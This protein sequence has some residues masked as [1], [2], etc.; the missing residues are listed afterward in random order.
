[1]I[2]VAPA[3]EQVEAQQSQSSPR[4]QIHGVA[5]VAL[6]GVLAFSIVVGFFGA[7]AF[8]LSSLQ[9]QRSQAQ[10]YASFR[11]LLDPSSPIAPSIGGV[12]PP[13]SPIALLNAP[14]ADMRNVVVVEGTSSGDT[15]AGPG[16]LRDSPLPGQV[17]ES[18]LMGRSSTAGSPFSGITGLR[19]GAV[20][21]VTTGQGT[22]RFIVEGDRVAGDELP[23]IPPSGA[24]LTLV[25]SAGSGWLGS[26]APSHL[27]YVD[28]YLKGK[29]VTAPSGRP[30]AVPSAEI[31]GHGDPSAWPFVLF[32]LE[33]LL[34]VGVA[35]AWLWSRWGVGKTWLIGGPVVFAIL[36]LLSNEVLRLLPN[37]Y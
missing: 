16:H 12:I 22:F 20:I 26:F 37:V 21:T 23:E 36:W 28:A 18:I 14:E 15:L 29:A 17:G 8:G 5:F 6:A 33:A 32:W 19:K 25:T 2:A 13:G 3:L 34:V 35:V 4:P 1:M 10:L 7:F 9:E 24:L 30:I 11:G 31:Q 27:L